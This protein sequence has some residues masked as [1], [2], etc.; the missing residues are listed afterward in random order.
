M[1]LFKSLFRWIGIFNCVLLGATSVF[2]QGM[3]VVY[4]FFQ[5]FD[6]D[7]DGV[8]SYTDPSSGLKLTLESGPY[9]WESLD[10]QGA[11]RLYIQNLGLQMLPGTNG[12]SMTL[13][14]NKA[15]RLNSYTNSVINGGESQTDSS[16]NIIR[17]SYQNTDY[18]ITNHSFTAGNE[19]HTMPSALGA[20]TINANDPITLTHLNADNKGFIAWEKLSVTV[21]P[22]IKNYSLFAGIIYTGAMIIFLALRNRNSS[23]SSG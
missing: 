18:D 3:V 23:E 7:R 21:I 13:T 19:T 4:D 22:E 8:E 1:F 12:Y 14:F 20:L 11:P 15:V 10:A 16:D 6:Y 9:N 5:D 2:A 17:L